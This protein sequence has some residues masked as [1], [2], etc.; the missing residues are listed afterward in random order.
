MPAIA[1]FNGI[2]IY[3]YWAD[4][5]VPHLHAIR[6]DEEG[7]FSIQTG[8]LIEG[9]VAR[10]TKRAVSAWIELRR[11]ELLANWRRGQERVPFE[12]VDG[13]DE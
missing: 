4:H 3:M 12:P 1:S 7:V 10:R 8:E 2:V 9:E 6:G 5:G 11:D 13:P